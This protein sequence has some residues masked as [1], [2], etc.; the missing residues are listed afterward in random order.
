MPFML[1]VAIIIF[2]FA[3]F[4]YI[5]NENLRDSEDEVR[6]Y[7]DYTGHR[8]VDVLISVYMMG[9][10]GDFEN[11]IYRNGY[12]TYWA[13]GMFNM[14]TFIISVVFMNMLIAIMGETFGVVSEESEE[15]GLREQVVLIA[16]HSWLLD[17][18]KIFKN[19]KYVIQVKPS[20]SSQEMED[21]VVDKVKDAEDSILK[22]I[23]RHQ[24]FV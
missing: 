20:S 16:D 2:S 8:I 19:Q 21:A 5:I 14:A 12:D 6:Y 24:N 11:T 1:M 22:R 4:Y 15:S 23:G 7:S 3:N 10:L 18:N 17:L 13:M 9:A